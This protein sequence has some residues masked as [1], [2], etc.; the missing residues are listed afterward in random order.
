M[1]WQQCELLLFVCLMF[2]YEYI[3]YESSLSYRHPDPQIAVI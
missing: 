1:L 3:K 2:F